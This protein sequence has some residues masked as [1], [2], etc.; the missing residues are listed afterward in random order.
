MEC[1]KVHVDE[2]RGRLDPLF[3]KPAYVVNEEIISNCK[4]GAKKLTDITY[5]IVDGPFGSQLK[6]EEY[7]QQGIP[8]IRVSN[9]RTGEISGIFV[10]ISEDKQNQLKRSRVLPN[11]VLL[12]KAGAILG[13]SAVFPEHLKEG[14][15]TSHLV[16]IT[17][18]PEI[19]P[20]Y[21]T[22]FF[23]T[24]LGQLQIYRWGNKTTRPELNTT[25]VGQILIPIP[26][27]SIQNHIVQIMNDAYQTKKQKEAKAKELINSFEDLV[28]EEIGLKLPEFEQRKI[29]TI[30]VEELDGVFNPER[31]ANRFKLNHSFKWVTVGELG[32]INRETF[33][34]SKYDDEGRYSLLRIDD[35]ENN[36]TSAVIRQVFGKN[37]G[38]IILKVKENDVLIARLGPTIENKK[39]VLCPT[40]DRSLIASNEFIDLR[41]NSKNNPVFVLSMLKTGFYKKIMIQKSRGATPSR[42]RLSHEDFSN[43]PFPKVDIIIQNKI[44]EEVKRR[45]EKAKQLQKEAKE[46]LEKAILDVEKLIIGE[47]L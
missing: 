30:N 21:L 42:R 28:F 19:L 12:T 40:S 9:V 35:L 26:P 14:N 39:F 41:C 37:V 10:Y 44:A 38:G 29:F 18:K 31:Y 34:P 4:W 2:V 13:Y 36:P 15:I 25:E 22:I 20:K 46:E 43:L 6:V 17:C 27:P 16:A 3:Y 1:F 11:N 5:R 47:D 32:T 24:R 8:L 45:L 33:S 7:K 23:R